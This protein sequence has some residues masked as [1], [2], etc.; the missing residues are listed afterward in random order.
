MNQFS[1]EE[2]VRKAQNGDEN[3]FSELYRKY[4]KRLEYVANRLCNNQ[5]DAKDAVQQTFLQAHTSLHS[6]RDPNRF[7]QWCCRIVH[8]KC[9]DMFRKNK[10]VNV[11]MMQSPLVT[12]VVEERPDYLPWENHRFK[13]DQHQLLSFI[14][15][16]PYVQRQVVLLVY[17]DQ[18]SMQECAHCLNV[19]EGTVKSRLYSA[20]RSLREKIETYNKQSSVPLNFRSASVPAWVSAACVAS[21]PKKVFWTKRMRKMLSA[22][23]VTAVVLGAGVYALGSHVPMR[24]SNVTVPLSSEMSLKEAYFKLKMWAVDERQ[25]R[26]RSESDMKMAQSYYEFLKKYG[27]V[28]YESLEKSGWAQAF[29]AIQK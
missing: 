16:L 7:Y 10:D 9:T 20:K 24:E 4:Q 23:T 3:A 15:Q 19:P 8:G 28:Y 22:G 27:G 26:D 25:M 14:S 1:D 2:L 5:E 21:M 11:D 18:M 12:S 13:S 17:F 6:L 29:E